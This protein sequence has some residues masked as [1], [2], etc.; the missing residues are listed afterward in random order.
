MVEHQ[1]KIDYFEPLFIILGLLAVLS[2]FAFLFIIGLAIPVVGLVIAAGIIGLHYF[3][4]LILFGGLL[5]KLK[6]FVPKLILGIG[7]L[8]PLP[9]LTL[10]LGIA[11]VAQNRFIELVITQATLAV[12]TGGVGNVAAGAAGAAK[13]A[14]VAEATGTGMAARVAEQNISATQKMAEVAAKYETQPGLRGKIQ[15]RLSKRVGQLENEL[16]FDDD[17]SSVS[18]EDFGISESTDKMGELFNPNYD[19][20]REEQTEREKKLEARRRFEESRDEEVEERRSGEGLSQ[21]PDLSASELAN[22]YV[23]DR[24]R[25]S[26]EN[27]VAIRGYASAAES[28]RAAGNEDLA[29]AYEREL[30]ALFEKGPGWQDYT[31][32]KDGDEVELNDKTNEVNLKKEA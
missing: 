22:L 16:G 17:G 23:K 24:S 20:K 12:V 31:Q 26:E 5:F 19:E 6:H 32:K 27:D 1:E 30:A 9:L 18:E 2:D 10:A 13:T 15:E 29:K 21:K 8:L 11:I 7:I 25:W 28:A 3:V 4:G 14:Q